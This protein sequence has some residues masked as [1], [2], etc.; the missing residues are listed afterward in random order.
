MCFM[1]R[2]DALFVFLWEDI[3][4]LYVNEITTELKS[5]KV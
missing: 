4:W 2:V 5:M 3:K 1:L